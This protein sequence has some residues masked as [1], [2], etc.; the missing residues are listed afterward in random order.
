M[1]VLCVAERE[2]AGGR[3]GAM[4]SP[5]DGPFGLAAL[6][7]A[8]R[9]CRKGKAKARD[10]QRYEAGLL[11]NLVST[12][13]ALASLRWRPS[14]TLSF[15]V[16][17]PKLREIHASRFADRVTHHLLVERL[18]RLFEPVFIH[19]SYANR[20]GKGTHAAVDR[21]QAFMRS[22][23]QGGRL[24][25]YA[26]QLDIANYFNSIHRPTLFRL[27]QRRLV[28]AVR[29]Q[30]L[31]RAE[32]RALQAHCRALLSADPA[33]GVRRQG[34]PGRFA[35]IPSHKRLGALGPGYGLPVGNLTSQFFANV[36]L[37]ELDQFIK[38]QLKV[39]WY[40]RY[41]DDCAPRRREGVLMN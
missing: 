15:V 29:R 20:R 34:P 33:A 18:S 13:D 19:H 1:C 9:A 30:G 26:L 32:A 37:N 12:R 23:S 16:T 35:Q 25:V 7:R 27:I 3:D 41:V 5:V 8:Y 6:W 21:L 22:A 39:R 38:N 11:D 31:E 2:S 4:P 24:P 10:T 40:L 14:R 36:Y 17:R 28:R